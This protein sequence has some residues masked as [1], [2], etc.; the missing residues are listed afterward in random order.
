MATIVRSTYQNSCASVHHSTVCMMGQYHRNPL[1]VPPG[2]SALQ[3]ALA[4]VCWGRIC[5]L[6]AI[7]IGSLG[8]TNML[9]LDHK[10]S[11]PESQSGLPPDINKPPLES[12]TV[13]SHSGWQRKREQIILAMF[14]LRRS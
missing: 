3:T 5:G 13:H 2:P 9:P 4:V 7:E 1:M 11:S 10:P 6:G 12:V 8:P 14:R